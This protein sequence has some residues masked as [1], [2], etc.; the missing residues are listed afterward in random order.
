MYF[1]TFRRTAIAVACVICTPAFAQNSINSPTELDPI[2]VTATRSPEPLEATIGDNS[3]V[4]RAELDQLPDATL[5]EVLGR[6]RGIS[7]VTRGGPQALTTINLRGT[8]SSQSLVLV[9]GMR[10]NSPTDGL[11]VLNAIPTNA[12]ERIEIVRGAASSLYGADAIGG[13]INV[14]TRKSTGDHFSS[15]AS[16]GIGTYDSSEYTAGL[17]GSADK[18]SYSLYGGYGQSAG[19]NATNTDIG[20]STYNADKDSYYRSNIGGQLALTWKPG[21]TLSLQTTE[22]RV[23]AGFDSQY[24]TQ[25]DQPYN[26]RGIQTLS[27]TIISS[28]NEINNYWT[29]DVSASYLRESYETRVANNGN[30]SRSSEQFQYQW[31]NT[32]QLTES[33]RLTLGLERLEQSVA[34]AFGGVP[35]D[36]TNDADQTNSVFAVYT[37]SWGIHQI[38]ASI[39]NDDNSQYGNF[40]T[41]SLAYALNLTKQWQISGAINT[42]YKAPSFVDLYFPFGSGNPNLK[43]EQSRNIEVGLRYE[44]NTGTIAVTGFY[45]RIKD[46]IVAEAPLYFPENVQQASIRGISLW[47]EQRIGTNTTVG[48]SFDFLSPYNNSTGQLLPFIAQRTLK[49]NATHQINEFLINADW[50]LTSGRRDGLNTLGGYG[51]FNLGASYSVN[52]HLQFQVQWNNVFDKNY[53]L[54]KGYNTPGSNVFFNVKATY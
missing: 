28:S 49:L 34:A 3:V 48:G 30:Y 53:T 2:I 45:N 36:Y 27:N 16:A 52:K 9:D 21:Q 22:S 7:F 19:F 25:P 40:A 14:I 46:L 20:S 5:A 17:S 37:G 6:Q 54:V 44:H 18:W 13:V 32:F 15:Y 31:L 42:A 47:G 50:L 51:L 24:F 26:D 10:V 12:I 35:T 41:G 43:P 23:N 4:T 1:H 39:R 11:P 8:S 29:S 33:Q 38:Q